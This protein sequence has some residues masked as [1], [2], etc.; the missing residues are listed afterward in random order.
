MPPRRKRPQPPD[1]DGDLALGQ[2]AD[3]A[4]Q[5]LDGPVHLHRQAAVGVER[6]VVL[7]CGRQVH[8]HHSNAVDGDCQGHVVSNAVHS[9]LALDHA[10]P[11]LVVLQH[12]LHRPEDGRGLGLKLAQAIGDLPK[13]GNPGTAQ[14]DKCKDRG[15]VHYG[16]SC[17]GAA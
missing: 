9:V 16:L 15:W 13:G 17:T 14:A 5:D 12:H 4:S 3:D 8:H 7:G 2:R 10:Q 6:F 11:F 1:E